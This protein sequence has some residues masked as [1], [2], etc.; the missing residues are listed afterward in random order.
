MIDELFVLCQQLRPI[1]GDK[2]DILWKYYQFA[3]SPQAKL[4]SAQMIKM[5]ASNYLGSDLAQNQIR[6][7]PAALSQARGPLPMGELLYM[8]NSIGKIGLHPVELTKHLGIFGTTG[9]GK[10]N[11]VWH[12]MLGLKR[13]GI[14]MLVIDWKR[15]YRS[16]LNHPK[17]V[18]LQVYTIGRNAAPLH[19]NPLHPPPGSE[20]STWVS[21]LAEIFEHSH[22][23]GQGV[24][25]I[26][27][28]AALLEYQSR[29]SPDERKP[30]IP[31][32]QDIRDR[33]LR[34]RA[35]G[36]KALWRDSCLRILR[37]MTLGP[38]SSSLN[39]Q[40][41]VSFE[42]V[43][44][45]NTI[46]ELDLALPANIRTF[47]TESIIRW[48]HL[49]RLHQGE[50]SNLKHVLI[51]EE[52]HNVLKYNQ[53]SGFENLFRELRSFGQA[54]V[55][56]TQH[57]SQLPVYVLGNTH[58][59]VFMQL[60]HEADII[61]ARQ[62]LFLDRGQDR[63]LDLL[64]TGEGIIKVKGRVPAAHA[65]FPMVK[66]NQKPVLNEDLRS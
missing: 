24:A 20:F 40:E 14:P 37:T 35:S 39:T 48:I 45:S 34:T 49:C 54:L 30:Y 66:L 41:S 17:L 46:L 5:V 25:E 61:A 15:N 32:M 3:D 12:L 43:L 52:A 47:L 16:L 63:Y 31:T 1:I 29:S 10:T 7:P 2:A 44:A 65:R 9:S 53:A 23:G 62:S 58:S 42:K 60:T 18:D 38:L 8:N 59:L 50:S 28:E 27:I 21:I 56:V 64:K 57:P 19:W 13:L 55:A 11:L 26:F 33:I 6:L 51:L 36:R 4:Q 22:V